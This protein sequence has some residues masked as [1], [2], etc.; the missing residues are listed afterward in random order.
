[1]LDH[2][3]SGLRERALS[4]H[5]AG[6]TAEA[7][8]VV[9]RSLRRHGAD[10]RLWELLALLAFAVGDLALAQSAAEQ[11]S[12]SVPLSP[13]GQIVLAQCYDASRHRQAAVAIYRHLAGQSGLEADLLEPLAAGLGR[14]G[15]CQLALQV[16]REAARRLPM[17]TGPLVG[18]V[19]YLRRL[20]APVEQIL[21]VMFRAHYLD[22]E[23]AEYRVMLAWMLFESGLRDQA[24]ALLGPV[25]P[26]EFSCIRCLTLMQHVFESV[27]DQVHSAQCQRRLTALALEWAWRRGGFDTTD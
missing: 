1:M 23:R 8:S 13:R 12:L 3:S 16:C 18:I 7:I 27:G 2:D 21:P 9:R 20:R 17:E 25:A 6:N 26:A 11:A 24:A 22:S 15:E 4:L 14:Y 10:G 19:H 5:A